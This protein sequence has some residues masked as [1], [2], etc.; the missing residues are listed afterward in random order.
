MSTNRLRGYYYNNREKIVKSKQQID[1]RQEKRNYN[2]REK[3]VKSK[4]FMIAPVTYFYYN[5]R[6][7]IVKSKHDTRTQLRR[8]IITIAKK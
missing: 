2:N 5:N 4:P 3:I 7:K 6:E 1:N 8:F